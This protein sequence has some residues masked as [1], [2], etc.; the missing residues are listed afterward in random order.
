LA[1][2]A[3]LSPSDSQRW[4]NCPGSIEFTK[5]YPNR[6]TDAADEGTAAHW[7]RQ[8]C[9]DLGFN[10]Y[11]FIGVKIKVNGKI[12]ECDA[13]MA[14]AL[15]P[16]IEEIRQYDGQM[17]VEEKINL[18]PWM[19]GQFGTL[20]CGVLG[21]DLIVISDLKYGEGVAVQAVGNTQQMIYAL[22]F[23]YQIA[24]HIS[25]AKTFLII[26]DQPR[27]NAGGGYWSVTL[28][29]LLK[30]GE[31]L[32]VKAAETYRPGAPLRASSYGC[33][34][35]PAANLPGRMGG[36][37]VHHADKLDLLGLEFE[38]LDKPVP[39]KPP[40][41]EEMTFERKVKLSDAK[42]EI[43][44]WLEFIHASVLNDLLLEGP[45]GGKKAVEGRKLARRWLSPEVAEAFM[46]EKALDP[47]NKK[48]K[49][50][51]Q[52]ET[53]IGG[54]EF[55]I[56]AGLVERPK[57]KPIVVP[58]EDARLPIRPVSAEFE[59]LDAK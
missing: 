36:C 48:L 16:G 43:T 39:W 53:A 5:N 9:L 31:E 33:K 40:V 51:K 56:P 18:D 1:A 23:W 50:P 55:T 2:H 22:G 12:Y 8:M 59:D 4:L 44:Q 32:K 46:R 45:K 19:P 49:T 54:K 27:N 10:P 26:I 28:D 30:F 37:P 41:V 7:V 6:S 14:D 11:A 3:R 47:F 29:E 58:V 34:W 15:M 21:R 35:C 38:D 17:F 13:E 20:D 25:S 42:V 57:P 52:A 24:R